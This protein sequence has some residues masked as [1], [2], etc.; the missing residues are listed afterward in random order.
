MICVSSVEGGALLV[1]R[2]G[3]FFGRAPKISIHSS[4]GAGDSMVGA[5][6]AQLYKGSV[7][8]RLKFKDYT[9]ELMYRKFEVL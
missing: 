9:R 8:V 6:I 2:N 3:S 4:V 7:S 5:M 1:T